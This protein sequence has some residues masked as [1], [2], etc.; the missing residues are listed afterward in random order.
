MS[1]TYLGRKHNVLQCIS[2]E[3]RAKPGWLQEWLEFRSYGAALAECTKIW[4]LQI[5]DQV[6]MP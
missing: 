6:E 1:T 5:L 3:G 2:N 4:V